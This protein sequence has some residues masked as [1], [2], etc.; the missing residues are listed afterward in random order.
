MNETTKNTIENALQTPEQ[1]LYDIFFDVLKGYPVIDP[2][3]WV[4]QENNI[5]R[6][7]CRDDLLDKEVLFYRRE[8]IIKILSNWMFK[9]NKVN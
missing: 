6:V 5:R 2:P 8:D 7:T 9:N 3:L 4:K 1:E